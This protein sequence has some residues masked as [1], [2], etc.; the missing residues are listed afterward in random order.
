LK[1]KKSLVILDSSIQ[2]DEFKKFSMEN[3]TFVA[4]DY[5]THKKLVDSNTKHE[6]LD[7]YLQ[8]KERLELYDFV[9]SK[10][11]WYENLS[12]KS[13]FEFN[14][15]N[16]L[17]LMS[18]LEFH[19]FVLTVLIKLFSIKNIISSKS[20]NEIFVSEKFLK[21]VKLVQDKNK[22]HTF[23]S[24]LNNEKSFL[25]N[26]IE[27]R[28]NILSKPCTFYI[29]KKNYSSLKKIYENFFCKINN[30]WLDKKTSKEI[31]LLVEFNTSAYE[32]MIRTLSKSKK[33]VVVLNRR[34]SA[35]WNKN[36][37][38]ILKSN[39]VKILDPEKFFD[40]HTDQEFALEHKRLNENLHELW[41]SK[42]LF[43]IFSMKEISFWP[44][45]KDRLKKIYD[46]RLD[47]Y[48]KFIFQSRNFLT[49]LNIKK[50]IC[51]GESGETENV[52]LQSVENDV[53][54]ILLQHS[55]LRYNPE[56]KKLQWRYEDQ[57]MLG[58]TCKKFFLW[59]NSD[60]NY[61]L[62]N[63]KIQ[64]DQLI[65]SGSPRHDQF[66]QIK[67]ST[68][69]HIVKN[70]LVTLSPI[71]ERSGLGDTNLIIKY[72]YFLE[73]IFKILN[74]FNDL[75]ITVK[76][77]PG[78]NPHNSILIDFLKN[79]SN[80]TVFQIKNPNELIK[81]SDLMI[82]ISPELYDSSTIMLEGLL[83]RKPV[84]QLSLDDELS[85]VEP[86]KSPIIQISEI[87]HFEQIIS[88]IINDEIYRKE[89]IE[90]ISNKL[91]DY[92]SFQGNSNAKFLEIIEKI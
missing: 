1:E 36:S 6:L 61:F 87:E 43:S 48:L 49:Q 8:K 68:N 9:L 55:F 85:K 15:I 17:S 81:K 70:I 39:N 22:I 46:Y 71:S 89:I 79:Q 10:Y 33:Q 29:S 11:T 88:K 73:K 47:D 37:I 3:T 91:N 56:L 66:L 82:N 63:S 52:L 26:K 5:E 76:L 21:Y 2:F 78:E 54:S 38:G 32:E 12:R 50:I 16:I 4:A 92:L 83:L 25:T 45:I 41:K 44:L 19:E 90:Q 84:I 67:S 58:L 18:S 74:E 65:I 35:I 23:D 31:I 86:L 57:N 60:L 24:N 59:G 51:L 42:E 72:N 53:D 80:I 7:N 77:H 20:P 13:D 62:E 64:K 30:L 14:S 40:L 34:R 27:L 75:K 28:F 69:S